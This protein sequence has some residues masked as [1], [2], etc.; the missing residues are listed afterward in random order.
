M[1]MLGQ[2]E[3]V[4]QEFF[5][6]AFL[7]RLHEGYSSQEILRAMKSEL[8]STTKLPLAVDFLLAEI[9]LSGV[10]STAMKRMSH[11]FTPFQTFIIS[12]AERQ[13]GRFDFFIALEILQK[14]A[15]YRS[16]APT[17]QG[18]FFYQLESLSRNRLGFDLGLEAISLDPIFNDDWQKWVN[19]T[20]RRQIGII[21]LAN[22]IYVRSAYYQ[23]DGSEE[24]EE[25]AVLF[26][27]REGR[28]AWASRRR[29]PAFFFAALA[30]HLNYPGVP[31]HA[32]A[33]K[34]EDAIP[35]L[36]RRIELLENKLQLLDE[37]MHGGIKLEKFIKKSEK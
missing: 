28:I 36:K 33:K 2:E 5:F 17:P 23:K 10:M 7:E 34:T 21:D 9:R 35:V 6:Q 37:E 31:H 1:G 25:V 16:K 13:E 12:E 26:G 3:Y 19:I 11:Y 24:E 29:D 8:L 27:E 30:R 32:P 14:E 4:E 15:G 18:S 20:L 22:L